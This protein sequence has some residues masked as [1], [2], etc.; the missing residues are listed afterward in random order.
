MCENSY[1]PGVARLQPK[2]CLIQRAISWVI[3]VVRGGWAGNST[4]CELPA[5][6]LDMPD[7]IREVRDHRER[8]LGLRNPGEVRL[9]VCKQTGNGVDQHLIGG[10]GMQTT[11]LFERQ[12][13]L[14]PVIALGTGRPQRALAPEDAKA[15]GALGAVVGRLNAVLCQKHPKRVHLA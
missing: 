12:N 6:Q 8:R 3:F 14:H 1:V 5:S 4:V 2:A 7:V 10:P 9:L 15:Q 11:R 13:P